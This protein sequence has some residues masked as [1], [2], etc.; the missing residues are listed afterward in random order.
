MKGPAKTAAFGCALLA[1][2]ILSAACGKAAPPKL[3]RDLLPV[4]ESPLVSLRIL[5]RVGSAHDPSGKEG[6]ARLTWSL[7][8]GGG[9]RSMSVR[10]IAEKLYPLA[11]DL[12][13]RVDKEMSAFSGTVHRDNLDR[14]YAVVRE[15]LL[16]PGFRE[17]DFARIKADQLAFLEKTLAGDRDEPL[18]SEILNLMLYDGHPYGHAEAGTV[19][20]VEGLTLDDAKAFYK[21]YFVQGNIVLGLAGGYPPD[22]PDKIAADFARLPETFTPR[23]VLPPP[24]KPQ[25][26][27]FAI[28]DKPAAATSIEMGFP[29][30]ITRADKDFFALWV[31]QAHFGEQG[32]SFPRLAQKIREERGLNDGDSAA[33]EHFVQGRDKSPE[34][35]HGRQQQ[36]FSIRIRPVPDADRHFVVRQALRELRK[37]VEDGISEERFQLVRAHLLST[38]KLYARTLGERLGWQMDA[39]YYGTGDILAAAQAALPR[40][41]RADVNRAIRK[42]LNFADVAVAVV[43]RDAEAFK[44]GL[45]ADSPS[46]VKYANPNMPRAVLDEDAIIQEY[47]LTVAADN[48]RTAPAAEFFRKAGLPWKQGGTER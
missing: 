14:Y 11:A 9:S 48:A 27:E 36:V 24:R 39:H 23:L 17:D 7:L 10:D 26:L 12:A 33:I 38:T 47:P 40:L 45:V 15:M 16:D 35:N 34:P 31:A 29:I 3:A 8:A 19:E 46:P 32:R 6:L 43:T 22:F 2:A 13:L 18:A 28:A 41:T 20:S 37:L 30:A 5:V 1:A 42:Y 4:E 44:S 21:E 25:G